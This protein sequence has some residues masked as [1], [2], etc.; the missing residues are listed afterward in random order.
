MAVVDQSPI[1]AADE[2]AI[3]GGL[4]AFIDS[5]VEPLQHEL[6]PF[7]DDQRR[8]FTEDGTEAPEV[9]EARRTVRMAS[10]RAGYYTMFTPHE[11]G[12]SQMGNRLYFLCIEAIG[13]RY[14]PGQP[15][16]RL[17]ADAI[18]NW[19]CGPGPIWR[20][21]STALREIALPGLVSG[22][23]HGAFGLTESTGGS[24]VW[25]IQTSAVH[26]G[27]D[28]V[29]NGA[30]EWTS[31]SAHADFVLVFAVTDPQAKAARAGGITCF[32]IPTD[33]PGFHYEST[34]RILG[35]VGGREGSI[36][37]NDVRVPDAYRIGDVGNGLAMA[38]LTITQ[39]RLWLCARSCGES[40]WALERAL[41]YAKVRRTFGKAIAEHQSIQNMLADMAVDIYAARSMAL[42]CASRADL[43]IDV[44]TETAMAK[45]YTVGVCER[46]FDRAIQVHGGIGFANEMRLFD[47][48]KAA[49]ISRVTEGSDEIM[50]RTIA[51]QL[52]KRPGLPV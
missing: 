24:D 49:R 3:V 9:I 2:E 45:L 14:G 37:F 25:S 33:T 34:I 42:D 31:W 35:E 13:Q 4:C 40:K 30:K 20:H 38:F 1:E 32:Y 43:G 44:R 36:S 26:D 27:D 22:E 17:A 18:S 19:F 5:A 46:V 48:W 50:R 8:Y 15:A 10:A 16:E 39:T 7:F 29:I 12:G 11:L 47:G 6:A 28:W 52:L 51:T 21:A 23:R 41:A